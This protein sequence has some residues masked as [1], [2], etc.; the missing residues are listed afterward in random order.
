MGLFGRKVSVTVHGNAS[1]LSGKDG[2][3]KKQARK[4][5]KERKKILR[6][7]PLL[8]HTPDELCAF[9]E[10]TYGVTPLPKTD[11]LYADVLRTLGFSDPVDLV[12]YNMCVMQGN[13]PAAWL[14]IHIEKTRGYLNY[15]I[16]EL[17]CEDH[18][19]VDK[20]VRE[21]V[22]FFGASKEDKKKKTDRYKQ[23]CAVQ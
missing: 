22:N 4:N 5:E 1:T 12:V 10:E 16:I 8:P 7:L 14:E 18:Y 15:H 2:R 6:N 20:R 23:Y 11:E 17:E 19:S 9:I 13:E 21:I 3:Y